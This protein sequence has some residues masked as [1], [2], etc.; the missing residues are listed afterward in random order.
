MNHFQ[1]VCMNGNRTQKQVHEAQVGYEE[2]SSQFYSQVPNAYPSYPST[3]TYPTSPYYSSAPSYNYPP[4]SSY[5][6][7]E[8]TERESLNIG[9]IA[10]HSEFSVEVVNQTG[11]VEKTVSGEITAIETRDWL[12]TLNLE[13]R[14]HHFVKVDTG[15]QA[16]VIGL[17]TLRLILPHKLLSPTQLTLTAYG[18]TPLPVSGSVK[19]QCCPIRNESLTQVFEF[20]VINANVKTVLGL[21]S[22]RKFGFINPSPQ[23]KLTS[24]QARSEPVQRLTTVFSNTLQVEDKRRVPEPGLSSV[25]QVQANPLIS[26]QETRSSRSGR[27]SKIISENA[28]IF[29]NTKVGKIDD[30]YDI[31]LE[32]GCMPVISRSRPV[33]FAMKQKIEDELKRMIDLDIIIPVDEPTDWVNS[34]VVVQK[35]EKVRL[36]LD[37]GALNK[38][39]K[40][41]HTQMPTVDDIYSQ[42]GK[43]KLFSKLDLKDGYWHV[44]LSDAASKLTTF[45]T[46]L[47]RYR[48]LR[49]PFGLN[50]ANEVFFKRTK[51]IFEG[52]PGVVVI[53]D[54]V[55]VGADNEA[56][57][58]M[59]L[60]LAFERA[61]QHGV[62]LNKAKCQFGLSQVKYV[63]HII[64][65]SGISVDP[66]K[67]VDIVN[68]PSPDDKKGV[69]RILGSLNFFA[70]YIPDMSTITH[71]IRE[72]LKKNISFI[73]TPT[74]EK[75]FAHIKRTLS[76]APV[77]GY[78]DVT[79]D[80]ILQADSSSVGLGACIL[81]EGKPIAYASR[82]L[83]PTQV[84]Y[85]QIEKELLAIVFGCERF[86]QYLYGKQ[87]IVHTD[88]KPLINMLKKQLHD[89]PKRIQR[90][91]LRLQCYNLTLQSPV[92]SRA[93]STCTRHAVQS[94]C[95]N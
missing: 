60:R 83:T 31:K 73:W 92:C 50:S 95:C 22:S 24:K 23:E 63:G 18:G 2:S 70:R 14:V 49:L 67:V 94:L 66:D 82:S 21:D 55:L 28:D 44:P 54:D 84:N 76:H 65:S 15:A 37:P 27:I 38:V 81:Q 29:D 89:N 91:L 12:E 7:N 35:G 13:N 8:H 69:Q 17:H 39:I 5:G 53:Y 34:Y 1:Q 11:R 59:R 78:Y 48:F 32:P 90:L 75:A 52:L 62:K 77:L 88:H 40:R 30:E 64:S 51:E 58:D 42:I 86:R 26:G 74:H 4:T 87:V 19:I 33:P 68:M 36:C 46:H 71:P 56:E 41:E 3:T 85:A 6:A 57:H 79:K 20:I 10:R 47:G 72:L 45:Q 93:R 61:R 16:N 43:G 9:C 25:N 80:I